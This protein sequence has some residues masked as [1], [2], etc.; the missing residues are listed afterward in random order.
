MRYLPPLKNAEFGDR[1]PPNFLS[2]ACVWD[3]SSMRSASEIF[4]RWISQRPWCGHS[5]EGEEGGDI[6][7]HADGDGD[8]A[9]DNDDGE[10][11]ITCIEASPFHPWIHLLLTSSVVFFWSFWFRFWFFSRLSLILFPP[12]FWS[13]FFFFR[14]QFLPDFR[15]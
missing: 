12:F 10:A 14:L 4:L 6:T 5:K 1:F 11:T 2:W 13:W 9:D 8:G 15:F 7:L 3:F